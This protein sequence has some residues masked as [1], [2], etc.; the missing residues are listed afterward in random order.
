MAVVAGDAS[1]G[2]VVGSVAGAEDVGDSI[3]GLGDSGVDC[4]VSGVVF[5][6]GGIGRF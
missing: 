5:A 2:G 3:T 1:C 4:G 6:S